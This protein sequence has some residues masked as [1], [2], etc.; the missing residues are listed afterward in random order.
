MTTENF[1]SSNQLFLFNPSI[2]LWRF[3]VV[4][5]SANESSSS[6]LDFVINSLPRNGSCSIS[7]EN[8]T[9]LTLFTVTCP[10]W[11]DEDEIK[12]YSLFVG[13]ADPSSRLLIAFSPVSIF[14][15]LLPAGDDP[16]SLLITIRDQHDCVTVWNNLSSISVRTDS[17]AFDDLLSNV[18]A[19][20][21]SM[22][23]PFMRLLI[24]G[25]QNQVGQVSSSLSQ[26]LNQLDE[27]NLHT[28][29]SSRSTLHS[30]F[31]RSFFSRRGICVECFH[32]SVGILSPS[33]FFFFFFSVESLVFAGI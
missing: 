28:A 32:L 16:L 14:E 15:V 25:N 7:P 33:F 30:F 9:A 4:Y 22:T 27:D 31:R 20:G 12:D 1:T 8:G 2:D 17:N 13:S 19:G 18:L 3:Q 21:G 29:I 11:F 10:D 5:S 26:H 6:A 24:T 23:N